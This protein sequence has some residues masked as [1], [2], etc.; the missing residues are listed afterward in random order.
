MVRT[1]TRT[2]TG[3]SSTMSIRSATWLIAIGWAIG[4]TAILSLG[5]ADA[6]SADGA[7]GAKGAP[8][9]QVRADYDPKLGVRV[10][11]PDG[12]VELTAPTG[13]VAEAATFTHESL[14]PPGQVGGGL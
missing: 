1:W 6:Q 9:G 8:R 5:S 3:R 4:L 10:T 12:G 2:A 13:A 11:S 7:R 14:D